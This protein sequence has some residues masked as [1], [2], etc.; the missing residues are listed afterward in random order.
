MQ[1]VDH[2]L[3]YFSWKTQDHL[4]WTFWSLHETRT[5]TGIILILTQFYF[6]PLNFDNLLIYFKILSEVVRVWFANR[7]QKQKRKPAAA[8][9]SSFMSTVPDLDLGYTPSDFEDLSSEPTFVHQTTSSRKDDTQDFQ[10]LLS[11]LF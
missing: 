3:K 5:W 1:T 6:Y 8:T 9:S 4:V 2:L 7:R 11:E 10:D